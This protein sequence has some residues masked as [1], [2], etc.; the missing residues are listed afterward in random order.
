MKRSIALILSFLPMLVFGQAADTKS[1]WDD[2]FTDP[3][4]PLYIVTAMVFITILLVL[5]VAVYMLR[6]LNLMVKKQAEE[7][8]AR[9]GRVLVTEA[10]W[11]D[12]FW[13]DFN[14]A[15]PVTKESDIDLGHDY[16][17]IRELDNHLP[18][19]WK[20]ILYFTIGWGVV[21][22]IVYHVSFSLPSSAEEYD[23]Q[24]AEADAA[25]RALQASQPAAVIDLNTL[26]Y[27]ANAEFI[28]KGKEV[29]LSNACQSCHGDA[30]GSRKNGVGPNL[31]DNFWIHGGSIKDIYT[32]IDKGVVEKGMPAW[33]KVMSP[34]DV[35]NVT[36]YVMS[37]AGT[38]PPD[39]KDPQGTEYKPEAPMPKADTTVT[40]QANQ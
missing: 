39:A 4:L 10:S 16:D 15:V 22:M 14:A 17:G 27:D 11:W 20:G 30:G 24:V 32:T 26:A 18:P 1:F 28:A 5:A 34:A 7:K 25:K 9:E 40:A 6:I 8:A 2:P 23:I 33:G 37:L 19:W 36:F 21:Y 29:Y 12:K 38:N 35:R 3:M 31:T 13:D